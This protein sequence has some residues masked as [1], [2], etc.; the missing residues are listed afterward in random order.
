MFTKLAALGLL[1]FAL[2]G[3]TAQAAAPVTQREAIRAIRADIDFMGEHV[4]TCTPS[5]NGGQTCIVYADACFVDKVFGVSIIESTV[6]VRVTRR[7]NGYRIVTTAPPTLNI[8]DGG[9]CQP[10][11]T[12]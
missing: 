5:N 8:Y 2:H 12:W 1:I 6:P 4:G 3:A 10:N 9:N 11:S 7:G